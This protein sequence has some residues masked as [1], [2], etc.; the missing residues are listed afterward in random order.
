MTVF[1][2]SIDLLGGTIVKIKSSELDHK[3]LSRKYIL[4]VFQNGLIKDLNNPSW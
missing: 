1:W 3:R 2:I 4:F